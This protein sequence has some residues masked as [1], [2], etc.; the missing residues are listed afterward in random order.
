MVANCKRHREY[1]TKIEPDSLEG[2]IAS[3]QNTLTQMDYIGSKLPIYKSEGEKDANR[4]QFSPANIS[5]E[6]RVCWVR[7][8]IQGT[9]KRCEESRGS[10]STSFGDS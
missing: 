1:P 3:L 10:T 8:I 5:E 4:L 9:A 6:P 7:G 2:I